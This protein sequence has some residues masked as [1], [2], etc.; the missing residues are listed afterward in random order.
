[1]KKSKV[2]KNPENLSRKVILWGMGLLLVILFIFIVK[3]LSSAVTPSSS[4]SGSSTASNS[5]SPTGSATAEIK[6]KVQE[7]S[8]N[9]SAA[10]YNPNKLVVRKGIIVRILTSSTA[11]AGCERGVMIPDFNINEPLDIGSDVLEFTPDKTGTF[12][13]MCQMR[14]TKGILEVIS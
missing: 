6:G 11:D 5:T 13:F 12:E 1:M 4:T 7:V 10:G 2:R 9:I 8:L 14:M 3:G